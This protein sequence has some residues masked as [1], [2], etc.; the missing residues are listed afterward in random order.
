MRSMV[1]GREGS[2]ETPMKSRVRVRE[3][4]LGL[5]APDA[6]IML[7]YLMSRWHPL[8]SI[9]EYLMRRRLHPF[10]L[11]TGGL[12]TNSSCTYFTSNRNSVTGVKFSI[13]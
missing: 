8:Y 10:E 11:Y 3:R 13:P 4:C 9:R 2:L 5:R 7:E 1:R 12:L 6:S